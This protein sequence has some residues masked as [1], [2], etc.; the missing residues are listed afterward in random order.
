MQQVHKLMLDA[1]RKALKGNLTPQPLSA[2]D[3]AQ[4]MQ[5]A[6]AHSLSY[7]AANALG[8]EYTKDRMLALTVAEHQ[9]HACALF[10]DALE[11]A[12]IDHI[13]LKG[14]SVR[15]YYPDP[16]MR[17]S[18]DVDILVREC[19]LEK[20]EAVLDPV[21]P[22]KSKNKR[23]H[24]IKYIYS[25]ALALELHFSISENDEKSDPTLMQVWDYTKPFENTRHRF[26]MTNEFLMFYLSAHMAYHFLGGGCGIRSFMDIYVL[27]SNMDYDI[28]VTK[29]LCE[30][31]GLLDFFNAVCATAEVW[32]GSGEHTQITLDIEKYILPGGTYGSFENKMSVN[33][34]VHKNKFKYVLFG[35][36]PP[37][38]SMQ[39]AYPRLEKLPFLLPVY[40]VFRAFRLAFS[41]KGKRGLKEMNAVA[42]M[43]KGKQDETVSLLKSLGLKN[44]Q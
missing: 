2:E 9:K 36:F 10:C 31:C 1:V 41:K 11:S 39:Y 19:D 17:A 29:N 3:S 4:L 8:T 35:F 40:W 37:L 23:F 42:R 43:D 21:M 28:A 12:G 30:K 14:P 5:F 18:C 20:A 25:P 32:F 33:S 26:E 44:E 38:K 16:Y 15:K 24:D 13:V 27:N 22:F 6:R 34:T 7:I